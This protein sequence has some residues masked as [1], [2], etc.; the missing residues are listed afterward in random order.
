MRAVGAPTRVADD[1]GRTLPFPGAEG[2]GKYIRAG[3]GGAVY[4]VTNL[5][6]GGPGSLRAAVDASGPRIVVFRVSGTID[7]KSPLTIRNPISQSPG[8]PRP[9]TASR[10]GTIPS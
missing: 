1:V 7:L 10:S 4:E 3:R 8:R 9:E 2:Y 5:E 6:D